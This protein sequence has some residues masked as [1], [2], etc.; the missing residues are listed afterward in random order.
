MKVVKTA[1][2]GPGNGAPIF[3]APSLSCITSGDRAAPALCLREINNTYQWE[4]NSSYLSAN[5][6]DLPA[7]ESVI[8]PIN[9][10][11]V[12]SDCHGRNSTGGQTVISCMAETDYSYDEASYLQSYAGTIP[13]GTHGAPPAS[14]RGNQT[15]VSQW[16]STSNSFVPS[17][18]TWY[19][20]G[21]LYQSIDPLGHTTSFSYDSVFGAYVTQTCSPSTGTVS[22]CVS[23]TY[24]TP[25]GLLTSFTDQN[26]QTTNYDY[27]A[28]TYRIR[29]ATL[30]S[31]PGNNNARAVTSF[32]YSSSTAPTTFPFTATRSSSISANPALNDSST[33]TYDGLAR[34]IK[35]QHTMPSGPPSTV[36]TTYYLLSRVATVSNPYFSTADSTYGLVTN[37]YDPL[38]RFTSVKKQDGSVSSSDYSSG[39]CTLSTD[40]AGKARKSCSDGLGRL[41]QVFE[42]PSGLN[43]ETDYQY[44]A[45]G[46][47]RRVD[48]KGSAPADNSQWRTRL[49]TYDS[50]SRLLTAHNP[51]SG[52][53]TYSYDADGNLLQK[54]SPA[55]N[56][57]G[58]AT[59]TISYCYDEL[60]RLTGKAYSA[61]SC[62]LT[63]PVVTYIYDSGPNAKGKLTGVTDQAGTA[64]YSYDVLGRLS[65]ETR[66]IAGI[67]KS[68]SYEY[69]L[70]G[71][72][73]TLHYPSGA[74]VTYA[75]DS[76]GRILSAID[77]GNS[78]NYVTS[79][80]YQA[81]NQMTG[82][83][84]GNGGAFAGITSAFSYNKRLQPINMSASAPSQT[85]FSIGYDFHLGSGSTGSDNGNV[86]NIYN[87]RDRTRDQS[88]NYD[89]LNRLTSAS[90]A[91][92]N[93]AATTVNGKT[94]Y[95][96]NSYGY[97]AW[98]NLTAKSVTKCSA[99]NMS[100]TALV[101]NQLSG[102]GYDAVGNMT[103]DPTD[104]V[105]NSYDAENRI[106]SATKAG[107]TTSYVYDADGN[108]V[109]K[110]DGS[111][112]TLYWYMTPG[113]I[114]ESDL[115]GTM[116]SEYVFFDGERVARK[117]FSG[118]ATSAFYYFSDHLK[119]ASVVTDS[120]GNIKGESDYY[121]WGGE[122]QFVNNDSNHYKFTG[123]ERDQ[124]TGLDNFGKRYY[125]NALGRFVTPDPLMNSGQPWNP[126]TW[127][128]YTYT[129]NNPLRYTDPTGLYTWGNCSGTADQCKADQQRFRDSID[130]AKE[131]LK[132]LDPKSKEAKELSKTIKKLGEE[133]KGNIKINFGDA[134]KTD[135]Q[136]N[137]GRTVG[138]SITIN[139]DAVDSVAKGFGLNASEASALDAGV[140]THEGTHAGGAPSVLGFVGMHGE[141]A[142]YF[143][144][145]VTYQG[146]HNTDR[147]FNLWNESW[148][149]VDQDKLS[150]ERDREHSIQQ[151]I[152]PPKEEKKQENQQ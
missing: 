77:S 72:L 134:G 61:Q 59:Q 137:L 33:T 110:T 32:A 56:Q 11:P 114:G 64:N 91:G 45:L 84:S 10:S 70:D 139:Y 78:I 95:W 40:E 93:C 47:L 118:G 43:Y 90:N 48:Q 65:S 121:P 67:S 96:G 55:P 9:T 46:N 15:T 128:R 131:A 16:L 27:E 148:L 92:T 146:L 30:P 80:T 83:V 41:V 73:K 71:S 23:G 63:S 87:F 89:T 126:Q 86:W 39:N 99:E 132:G 13:S 1:D 20:T 14:V 49:F 133:G 122:L 68:I 101:N 66:T 25:T 113:I 150:I 115:S 98:G 60:H 152:H 12:K 151:A 120:A 119:T 108:R 53:I 94:E 31:D 135:G 97:D 144:E 8:D 116:K 111:T 112:G 138:N 17:H 2:F 5:L 117:D 104:G 75:P 36:D 130:K 140:T 38:D 149:T 28:A 81:D 103:S 3:G 51:E 37:T 26:S 7:Y 141:H 4:I 22:H 82:F 100:L 109:E 69:N 76:A 58:S 125:G 85:V 34:V 142:A 24:D 147:P 29:S 18:R 106:G 44:D 124:E 21:E 62:P 79:A 105:N 42:D 145:S 52:T 143:T 102:Y 6:A 127:N 35:I 88:F 123:K 54:T 50:L 136:S 129:L 74:A 57:T 19:D 107:V